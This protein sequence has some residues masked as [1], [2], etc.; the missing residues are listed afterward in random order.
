MCPWHQCVRR[1]QHIICRVIIFFMKSWRNDVHQS[2]RMPC[3]TSPVAWSLSLGFQCNQVI[4]SVR[5]LS[6]AGCGSCDN[7]LSSSCSIIFILLNSSFWAASVNVSF[8]FFPVFSPQHSPLSLPLWPF[9]GLI[10]V[11]LSA[12]SPLLKS[13]LILLVPFS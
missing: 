13:S 7:C 4:V 3:S 10:A 2:V 12:F 9:I 8:C 5:M 11:F 1:L 6:S